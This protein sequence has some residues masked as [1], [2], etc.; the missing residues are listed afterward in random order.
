MTEWYVFCEG[1]TRH[2]RLI[3]QGR[4]AAVE[5]IT[6]DFLV[7]P[8]ERKFINEFLEGKSNSLMLVGFFKKNGEAAPDRMIVQ[9]EVACSA[10][11]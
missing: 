8:K 9:T 1:R 10:S 5:V 11:A 7:T 4:A 3:I 2:P 6:K